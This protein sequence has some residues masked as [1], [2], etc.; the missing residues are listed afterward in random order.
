VTNRVAI[1]VAAASIVATLVAGAGAALAQT[2]KTFRDEFG[3]ISYSGNDGTEPFTGSWQERGESDGTGAGVVRV[4]DD[5]R[6]AGGTGNCLRIGSDGGTIDDFAA[7]RRANLEDAE[8]ASWSFAWRRKVSGS[9]STSVRV[10]I[11]SN[12]GSSWSTLATIPLNGSQSNQSSSLDISAYATSNTMVRFE[13]DGSGSN[14]FLFIDDVTIDASFPATTTTTTST[15]TTTSI[16]GPPTSSTTTTVWAPPNPTTSTTLNPG[17]ST[18]TTTS[19]ASSKTSTTEV[20]T[21]TSSTSTTTSGSATTNPDSPGS[22]TDS[23]AAPWTLGDESAP[24][25]DGASQV[26]AGEADGGTADPNNEIT[27]EAAASVDADASP[28]DVSRLLTFVIVQLVLLGTLAG[29]L[30]AV[31]VDGRNR[32]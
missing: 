22:S 6:C 3:S 9:A 19:A 27:L 25:D 2:P 17:A 16:P 10:R 24:A 8:S 13:G 26:A 21:G 11:S 28:N 32:S 31:G 29:V 5:T 7:D 18:T 14:A 15:S 23:T 20:G 12:G 1:A 30:A 4:V